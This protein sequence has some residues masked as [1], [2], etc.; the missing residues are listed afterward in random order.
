MQRFS[1]SLSE[2]GTLKLDEDAEDQLFDGA[3]AAVA[4]LI[5]AERDDI[6]I[7][8]STTEAIN[9][10]AWWLRPSAGQNVVLVEGD[11]PSVVLP[12]LRLAEETGAAIRFASTR[13][14]E[15]R[16]EAIAELVDENTAA[17]CVGHV[18]YVTGERLDLAVLGTLATGVG[19]RLVIDAT[20]SAGVVALNVRETPVDLLVA[21][22]HKWL[23]AP[24][25]VAFCYVSPT[26]ADFRPP[27]VG[28][29]GAAS[30]SLF[31]ADSVQLATNARRLE[32]G[33]PAHSA[34]VAL[35][36]GIGYLEGF[37]LAR[38][39]QHAI[40]LTGSLAAGLRD[41]GAQ[42]VTPAHPNRRAAIVAARFHGRDSGELVNRLRRHGIAVSSRGDALRFS[43]HLFNDRADVAAALD[44]LKTEVH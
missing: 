36:A 1:T 24:A 26:L 17:I 38:I 12:W 43:A 39:E 3:R 19:A 8:A 30:P 4:R 7:I 10:I 37:G 5:G 44:G 14:A 41:L 20:Q 28:W 31:A 16:T 18:H 25:G 21:S 32:L 23:C 15:Q 34:G 11:F 6:A 35:E 42:V 27:F 33:T 22:S 40:A 9:Q 2:S 13:A 29:R